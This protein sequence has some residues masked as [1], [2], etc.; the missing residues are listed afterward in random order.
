[1]KLTKSCLIISICLSN[2]I[3]SDDL[4]SQLQKVEKPSSFL[5]NLSVYGLGQKIDENNY[6]GLGLKLNSDYT[7]LIFEK[8]DYHRKTSLVQRIDLV[9]N[10]YTKIGLGF[11]SKKI[12]LD[13][14]YNDINQ[15]SYGC[16]LGYGYDNI[17]NLEFGYFENNLEN[18]DLLATTK[19]WYSEFAMK[20]DFESLT[21][22]DTSLSYSSSKAYDKVLENYTASSSFYPSEDLRIGMKYTST[23]QT[24]DIYKIT[25]NLNYSFDGFSNILKGQLTPTIV[26]SKNTTQNVT[27]ATEFK[28]SIKNRSLK[29]KNKFKEITHSNDIVARKVNLERLKEELL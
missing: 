23:Q 26:Y 1:M 3:S 17:Y 25:A 13:E 10:L 6:S 9:D 28:Q 11:L 15:Y 16:A 14:V 21:S 7:E 8:D 2:A 19:T 18:L 27:F 20:Y 24:E 12:Y 4:I 29:I 22:V 5:N